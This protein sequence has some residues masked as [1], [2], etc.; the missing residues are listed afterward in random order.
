MLSTATTCPL[1]QSSSVDLLE[2]IDGAALNALWER[3][4][5]IRGAVAVPRLHYW[6]CISCSLQFYD[7]PAA[8]GPD[9]YEQL[10]EFDW[11]YM[12]HKPE[13][14]AVL[15]Y[16]DRTSSVLEV[17]A[18]EGAFARFVGDR[19]YVGLE[20]NPRG[21]EAARTRGV[22]L[23]DESVE[24][25]ADAGNRYDLVAAFQVLEHVPYPAAFL[26]DCLRCLEPGGRL[27][28]AVPFH[29]GFVGE[30]VNPLLN[31]PPHHLTHWKDQTFEI[32]AE[33][34]GMDLRAIVHERVADYHEVWAR[35]VLIESRI[36]KFLGISPRLLDRRPLAR[37]ISRCS[38][39]A[40]ARGRRPKL[41][42]V[43]GH[44]V[45]AV[46]DNGH[47]GRTKTESHP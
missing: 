14:D 47:V 11:Y 17:G 12:A 3:R 45:I 31:M 23:I 32:A 19:R 22:K 28:V 15:P 13:F 4:L 38:A 46:L 33:L 27:I 5:S 36:R 34:L 41:D 35:S 1:C 42:N 2:E 30:A 39:W 29:D 21:I 10:Q 25:H 8:G 18:G 43:A 16:L 26:R 44:T 20:S 9:L 7:P 6:R 37:L 40:G 24:D